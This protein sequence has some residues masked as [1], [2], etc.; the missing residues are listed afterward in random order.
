MDFSFTDTQDELAA[1]TRRIVDDLAT[2][3]ALRRVEQGPDRFDRRLWQALADAGLLGVALPETVGGGGAGVLEQSRV[4]VE[5]GR[6]IAPVPMVSSVA[7]AAA[8]VAQFG[9]EQ[10]RAQWAAPAAAGETV[11]TVAVV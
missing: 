11:L 6:G 3:E 5:L 2:D 4:L 1:L 10:Q 8:A 9:S 7:M